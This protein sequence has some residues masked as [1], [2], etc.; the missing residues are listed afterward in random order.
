M[1]TILESKTKTVVIGPDRPLTIIGER[2][3]PTGRRQL[4]AQMAAGDFDRVRAEAITQ[5]E[6]GAQVHVFGPRHLLGEL[7][8]LPPA[9]QVAAAVP[10][11]GNVHECA[12]RRE[13]AGHHRRPHPPMTAV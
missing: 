5:V 6:A 1:D 12:A 13:A 9:E 11:V 10:H 8:Q 4:A 3:N 2:I 7:A